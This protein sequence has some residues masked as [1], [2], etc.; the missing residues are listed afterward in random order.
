ME[1]TPLDEQLETAAMALAFRSDLRHDRTGSAVPLTR[2][3]VV[4]WLGCNETEAAAFRLQRQ[5]ELAMGSDKALVE[6]VERLEFRKEPAAS[7]HMLAAASTVRVGLAAHNA[8]VVDLTDVQH[9]ARL[10]KRAVHEANRNVE[11]GPSDAVVV[12]QRQR[13]SE[14]SAPRSDP[15]DGSL[16]EFAAFRAAYGAG[17]VAVWQKAGAFERRFAPDGDLY[18]ETEFATY[19][20]D[21]GHQWNLSSKRRMALALAAREA[22]WQ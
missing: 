2:P 19:F 1:Q 5:A 20:G 7:E 13:L 21:N 8:L 11:V 10:G 3:H 15:R 9:G 12:A 18:T 6:D 14:L 17:A 16:R 4:Q 22:Q